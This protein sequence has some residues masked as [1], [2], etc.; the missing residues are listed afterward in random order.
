MSDMLKHVL[1]GDALG[2]WTATKKIPPAVGGIAAFAL[3]VISHAIMD[4][5]DPDYTVNWFNPL[6]RHLAV[7]FLAIQ[8]LGVLAVLW[9]MNRHRGRNRRRFAFRLWGIAGA[10]APDLIDGLY[11]IL[12][13]AAWYA[14]S[15]LLPWHSN[16]GP[17]P[18]LSMMQ[19]L[20]LSLLLFALRFGIGPTVRAARR[21]LYP[22]GMPG[23]D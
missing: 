9:L 17:I 15:L 14:G 12:N 6:E 5:I 21:Y 3:G 23:I 20:S 18:R 19:T 11:A 22:G 16:R 13:P 2:D 8:I 1:V 7:P 4:R 10:V